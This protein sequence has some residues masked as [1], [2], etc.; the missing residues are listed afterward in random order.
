MEPDKI[1]EDLEF[2]PATQLLCRYMMALLFR[3]G[4]PYVPALKAEVLKRLRRLEA[5]E[6][7]EN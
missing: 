2:M 4:R 6:G 1:N 7:Q 5:I 3:D